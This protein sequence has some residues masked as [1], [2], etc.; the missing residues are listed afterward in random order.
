MPWQPDQGAFVNVNRPRCSE[1]HVGPEKGFGMLDIPHRNSA[2]AASRT[3]NSLI[4]PFLVIAFS[5]CAVCAYLLM[6]ARRTTYER[7]AEV[8]TSMAAAVVLDIARNIETADLSLPAVVENLK[9]PEIER[10]DPNLRR[11]VL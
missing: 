11:L 7:A 2:R 3:I 4:A 1:V 8:A 9:R 5:F 10:L 6:E